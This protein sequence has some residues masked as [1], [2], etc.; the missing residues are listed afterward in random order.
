[1]NSCGQARIKIWYLSLGCAGGI[2]LRKVP[3]GQATAF[4][5]KLV[6]SLNISPGIA[7]ISVA[8]ELL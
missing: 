8:C 7:D 6:L 1:M 2:N 5:I 3:A 4:L